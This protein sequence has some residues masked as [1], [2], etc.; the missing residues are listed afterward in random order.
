[1]RTRRWLS[2]R[3]TDART[4]VAAVAVGMALTA[5][6]ADDASLDGAAAD[7]QPAVVTVAVSE[8][9]GTSLTDGD[10]RTLYL[11]TADS[12]GVS[13]CTGACLAVW[14]P[15]LTVGAPVTR[16][17]VDA[18]LL[19]TLTR[20]DGTVQVTY[21]G[22]P[23]YLFAGDSAAGDATGQ[24]VDGVWFVVAPDG[25]AIEGL[26]DSERSSESSGESSVYGY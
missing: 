20:D 26:S 12:P 11:F 18:S 4:T 17:A 23:L 8:T 25:T 1:M 10:G 9:F 7:G 14:P 13:T 24:G 15:L 2:G 16:G 5:C 22:W 21:G 3:R 6:G 19:G